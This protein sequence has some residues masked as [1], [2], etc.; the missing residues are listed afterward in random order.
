MSYFYYNKELSYT[1]IKINNKED[2][3]YIMTGTVS[4]YQNYVKLLFCFPGGGETALQFI[5][6]T[7]LYQCGVLC[8]VFEGQSSKNG[9]TFMNAYPW[10]GNDPLDDVEFVE[11]VFEKIPN[12]LKFEYLNKIEYKKINIFKDYLFLTG[13]SDGSGFCVYLSKENQYKKHKLPIKALFLVSSALFCLDSTKNYGNE[14]NKD[15]LSFS[16][17]TVLLHGT[18]DTIMPYNG[19]N[20]TNKQA[21]S[22][23]I[24]YWKSI[25]KN[26]ERKCINEKCSNPTDIKT[27]TYTADIPAF[28]NNWNKYYKYQLKIINNSIKSLLYYKNKHYFLFIPIVHGTHVWFGHK[29][30]GPNANNE[31]NL[32]LDSTD[33]L[34][35]ILD[36]PLASYQPTVKTDIEKIPILSPRLLL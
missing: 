31:A 20:Y 17:P 2:R 28:V 3:K 13:K 4:K 26:I 27:N 33:L 14:I 1:T 25:D 29:N 16:I 32:V 7:N 35:K 30:S 23:N 5:Q 11:K 22:N 18:S 24:D 10:F 36:I 8:I 6:Y 19:Q 12:Q 9:E 15:L 34:C 21:V